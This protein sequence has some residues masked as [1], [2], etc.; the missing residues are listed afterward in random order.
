MSSIKDHELRYQLANELHARPFPTLQ[1]PCR[2]AFL[3]IKQPMDAAA[4]D[5]EADRA[6]L[7]QLLDRYG[8]QHPQPGATHYFGQIGKHQLKWENHT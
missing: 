7:I 3:A 8:A 6:H 5:R 2:A 4:R 1:A